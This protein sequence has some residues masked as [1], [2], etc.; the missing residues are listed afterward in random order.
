MKGDLPPSSSE[1]FLWLCAVALRIARP[2]SVDPVNA[3]LSTSGCFTSASPFDLSPVMMFTTPAGSPTSW[4]IC[5]NAS[6]V[7][8]VNSAAFTQQPTYNV[9]PCAPVP[10]FSPVEE[11]VDRQQ[12]PAAGARHAP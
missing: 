5:A 4:Q 9:E 1:S 12:P 10:S 7:R 11:S 8:G 3:I 2:T 6:P